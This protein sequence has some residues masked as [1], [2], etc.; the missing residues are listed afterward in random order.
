MH[1]AFQKSARLLSVLLR[2]LSMLMLWSAVANL[3]FVLVAKPVTPRSAL[4]KNPWMVSSLC[5]P[6]GESPWLSP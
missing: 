2:S 4:P 3:R 6:E 1:P 5:P